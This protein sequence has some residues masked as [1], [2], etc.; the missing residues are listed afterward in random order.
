[1]NKK[2]FTLLAGALLGFIAV[3]SVNAQTPTPALEQQVLRVKPYDKVN[4][5]IFNEGSSQGYYV[6]QVDSMTTYNAG[7]KGMIPLVAGHSPWPGSP[8]EEHGTIRRGLT[9]YMGPDSLGQHAVWVDVMGRMSSTVETPVSGAYGAASMALESAAGLWC[10]NIHQYVQGQNPTFDFINKLQEELLEVNV[11]GHEAWPVDPADGWRKSNYK[12][13]ANTDAQTPG[14]IASWE[15]SETYATGVKGGRPLVAY[16]DETSDT[17]AVLVGNVTKG[18]LDYVQIKI[19]SATAVKHGQVDGMLLFT[20]KEAMPFAL[21]KPSFETVLGTENPQAARSLKFVSNGSPNPFTDKKWTVE[22]LDVTTTPPTPLD[23]VIDTSAWTNKWETNYRAWDVAPISQAGSPGNPWIFVDAIHMGKFGYVALKNAENKYLYT[24]TAYYNNDGNT[25]FL[26][27]NTAAAFPDAGDV[28]IGQFVW[29]M[30]YYPSGDSIYINPFSATYLPTYD[31]KAITDSTR[32]ATDSVVRSWYTFT[33]YPTPS[34]MKD[35]LPGYNS[36][37]PASPGLDVALDERMTA[38]L[39]WGY[40][41]KRI[42]DPL[43][44]SAG[45][46]ID[47]MYYHRLY[48]S[49]QNLVVAGQSGTKVTLNYGK[50]LQDGTIN[51]QINFGCYAPCK[52]A[53]SNRTSIDPDLYLI[54][55]EKGQ[56]LHVPLYSAHDSAVWVTLEEHV[57]PEILPSFQWIVEKKYKKSETSRINI[58]N[59]EFGYILKD[60]NLGGNAKKG[61]YGLAFMNIQMMKN[62]HA[63]F[64]MYVKN[65]SWNKEKVNSEIISFNDAKDNMSAKNAPTFIRLPKEYKNDPHLGYQWIDPDT[66]IVNLYAFNLMHDYDASRYLSLGSE[67]FVNEYPNTDTLVYARGKKESC[68]TIGYFRLDTIK[69]ENGAYK[70]Y[71]YGVKGGKEN[72]D[73]WNKNQVKD[74]VQLKRQPYRIIYEDPFKYC[75]NPRYCLSNGT[76]GNY[77]LSDKTFNDQI[78]GK[79]VFF[80]RDVYMSDGK[81]DF[82]LVQA[83]DTMS[84]INT[85]GGLTPNS[86]FETYLKSKFGSEGSLLVSSIMNNL[87]T[88]GEFNPGLFVAVVE[89]YPLKLKYTFRAEQTH[90][91]TFRLEKDADPIYRRF[92]TE[93]EG[94]NPGDAPETV[95]FYRTLNYPSEKYYLFENT[96]TFS[97]QQSFYN[98]NKNYLGLI[99]S[100]TNPNAKTAI[101]VDTAYVNRGTGYIKPQYML[102]IRPRVA[103]DSLG[104]DDDGE[105]TV[106]IKGYLRGMYLINAY[107]SAEAYSGPEY[108]NPYLYQEW[109]RLVFTDALH[110]YTKDALY[111]LGGVDLTPYKLKGDRLDVDKLDADSDPTPAAPKNGKIRKIDLGNNDHKDCVFSFRLVERQSCIPLEQRGGDFLIESETT[112]RGKE[113]KIRP[114]KGGWIKIHNGVPVLSPAYDPTYPKDGMEEAEIFNVEPTDEAPV[115][116]TPAPVVTEVKVIADNGSVTILNAAGKKVVITNVLGQ[117]VANTVLTSDRATVAAPQGV[118]VVAIEG[119]PAVKALVK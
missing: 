34:L 97:D 46:P 67:H 3:T 29:R 10:V 115:A 114:C 37:T 72:N 119:E 43:D 47:Y 74:L 107:D 87:K 59:R 4:P 111:I 113:P 105:L 96:G 68:H 15:F 11:Y 82:A 60:N 1:M 35:P 94:K 73:I 19:A 102:M 116:N 36:G 24:D 62:Q 58:I 69:T 13:G 88:A 20:L 42:V 48:V 76:E 26:K 12:T 53:T 81:K 21:D 65:W 2:N 6:L 95:K 117:T 44:P 28:M 75:G 78:L 23:M 77:S 63:P 100:E 57:H 99:S 98:T 110:S 108:Q 55:N 66:S 109:R 118:V 14:S 101:Y 17:V 86:V 5:L 93:L 112:E 39:K 64:K 83:V 18:G 80:L 106:K 41:P 90:F 51:T 27:F 9:L 61:E 50:S 38:R 8:I 54:R 16:L 91:S 84:I 49:L 71:G 25:M 79:P 104:C 40:N 45:A 85:G 52:L 92:N 30:V 103:E 22:Y 89:N 31:P 32:Y 56:Y 70:P 33:A 7:V